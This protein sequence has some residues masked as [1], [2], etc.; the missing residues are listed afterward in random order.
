MLRMAK[1]DKYKDIDFGGPATY[2]IV[3]QGTLDGGWSDRLDQLT[4]STEIREGASPHTFLRGPI[5]DQV[6]LS[7][8]LEN[9]HDL[10]LPIL[11]V[12]RIQDE[13]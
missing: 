3:V 7:S 1:S 10:H 8:L 11:S 12:E 6:E 2:R 13:P 4:I 5:R 9:L